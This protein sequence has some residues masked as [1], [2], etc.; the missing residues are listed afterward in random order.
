MFMRIRCVAAVAV[1]GC[2]TSDPVWSQPPA[3]DVFDEPTAADPDLVDPLAFGDDLPVAGSKASG[4]LRKWTDDSGRYG[5]EARFV[6]AD[7]KLVVLEQADGELV[8]LQ[9]EQLSPEDEE[10]VTKRRAAP[11]LENDASLSIPNISTWHLRDGSVIEGQLAG[12]GSQKM[13]VVRERG[14]LY[15]NKHK[16]GALPSAYDKILPTVVAVVDAVEIADVKAL[17]KHLA[18]L[19]GGPYEYVVEGV[20]LELAEGGAITIPI[21]LLMPS[22]AKEIAPNFARWKASRAGEISE[23]DR[24][25]SESRERLMLDSYARLRTQEAYQ[26][27]QLKMVELGLLQVE[28]GIVDAWEVTLIPNNAYGYPRSVVV[29]A[30]D[31]LAA[32]QMAQQRFPGWTLGAVRKLSN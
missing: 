24:Y 23:E 11:N 28:T 27:R 29:P 15:V 1:I 30:R 7:D 20:Q 3:T 5:V 8:V 19:G 13:V 22:D 4:E 31:S 10:F 2:F 25:A 21:S 12:F 18:A 17:E 16:L 9:R 32:Q 26:Q 14:E 6:T